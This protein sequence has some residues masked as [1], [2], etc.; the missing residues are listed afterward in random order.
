MKIKIFAKANFQE[1]Q[2]GLKKKNCK[3]LNFC[4]INKEDFLY[5][6]KILKFFKIGTNH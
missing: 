3:P 6:K 2:N 5:S 1:I 4:K